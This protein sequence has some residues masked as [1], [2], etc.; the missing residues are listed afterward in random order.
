MY[1]PLMKSKF[2]NIRLAQRKSQ[3]KPVFYCLGKDFPT[4]YKK[5]KIFDI[6]NF[7][8]QVWNDY[9]LKLEKVFLPYPNF[10]FLENNL[11]RGTMFMN[12]G[13]H[14]QKKEL[15]LLEDR[16]SKNTL[17]YLLEEDYV[18][19]PF[20]S[21]SKYLTSHN[22]IHHLYHICRFLN[23]TDCN[24]D[25][26]STI[27]E[28]GGGYG[29]MIKLLGRLN[30]LSNK[31]YIIIDTPLFSCIQWLYLST[32][33]GSD[34]INVLTNEK[35]DIESGKINLVTLGLLKDIDICADLFISTWGLSESSKYSQDF[36]VSNK[37]FNSK[38]LLLSYQINSKKLP[39]AERIEELAKGLA[40]SIEK[41][42]FLPD[43]YYVFK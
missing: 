18:G 10:S 36:V 34:C 17:C 20:L 11:I 19:K 8:S 26:I 39:H 24:F 21:N 23:K 4:L 13:G 30:A 38:H 28:W 31:T 9:N 14:M 27:V 32:I 16:F 25:K 37:W 3:Q 2:L 43:N 12:V 15:D 1:F 42:D 33:L 7:T 29:N 35:K 6:S 5:L 41:I 22:S 40:A